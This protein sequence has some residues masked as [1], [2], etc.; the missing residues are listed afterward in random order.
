MFL[1]AYFPKIVLNY[2][3]SL[4]EVLKR[5]SPRLPPSITIFMIK[6]PCSAGPC[7]WFYLQAQAPPPP[8]GVT[9][10]SCSRVSDTGFMKITGLIEWCSI[11]SAKVGCLQQE[12]QSKENPRQLYPYD[13]CPH[14]L[15]TLLMPCSN[16]DF[17]LVVFQ[18]FTGFFLHV[19]HTGRPLIACLVELQLLLTPV[20][21]LFSVF[22]WGTCSLAEHGKL[23]KPTSL[24]IIN[25][26]QQQRKHHFAINILFILKLK[27]STVPVPRK[28][29]KQINYSS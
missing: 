6:P 28:M 13:L 9:Q 29:T 2:F 15:H 1:Q 25:I 16:G 20:A 4:F 17:R 14:L 7:C 23:K 5:A 3:I 8:S 26:A 21:F 10:V 11:R 19:H 18:H 24:R 27:H 22:F 12:T